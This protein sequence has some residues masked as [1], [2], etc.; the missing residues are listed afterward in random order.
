MNERNY[1]SKRGSIVT[2]LCDVL[3][4]IDGTGDFISNVGTNVHARL[5]FWDE[6]TEYPAIHLALGRETRQYQGGGYKDRF[7]L[8]TVRCYVKSEEPAITLEGLLEDI[9][10]VIEKNGRL[11]YL[12]STNTPQTTHDIQIISIDTD[13]GVLDPLGVGEIVLQVRY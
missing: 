7:L 10:T 9:E 2:A 5:L 4:T 6:V 3:K 8:V 13:E 11:A 1:T 12:D